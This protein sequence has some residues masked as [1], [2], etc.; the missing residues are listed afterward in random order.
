MKTLDTEAVGRLIREVAAEEALPRWR[1]LAAGEIVEKNGP[2]D[3]VTIADRAVEVQLTRRLGDLLAGSDVVGEEAVHAN[4]SL[5]G[6]LRQP[7]RVWVIDPIDGTSSFARGEPGFAVMVALLV[8]GDPVAGWL[9]APVTDELTYAARGEG[10]WQE[11]PSG[12]VR[13]ERPVDVRRLADL[14]G[15]VGKRAFADERREAVLAKGTHFMALEPNTGCAGLDYPLLAAGRYHFAL[16]N[17]S[18]PWDHLPGLAILIE[19]GFHYA[20]HDGS[21]YLPGDN[22]GGLL[23]APNA[24]LW[25]PLRD[26]L[27]A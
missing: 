19:Q 18:E 3:L 6:R 25:R 20:R 5:V 23:V 7:G 10:A 26:I 27:L 14:R 2:D 11:T 8:D 1:N 9:Y 13:L 15:M 12:L 22:T 24:E 17:K 21:P 16:Y 4:P